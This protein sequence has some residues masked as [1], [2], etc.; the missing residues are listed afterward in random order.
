MSF[1]Y[2]CNSYEVKRDGI[3]GWIIEKY[4]TPPPC[5]IEKYNTPPPCIIKSHNARLSIK[6]RVFEFET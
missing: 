1:D 5:I 3:G 6:A 2:F 4:N